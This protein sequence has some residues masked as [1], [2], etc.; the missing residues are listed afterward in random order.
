[1]ARSA[2]LTAL[3]LAALIAAPA[4]HAAGGGG[5]AGPSTV[6]ALNQYCENIPGPTGGHSPRPGAPALAGALPPSVLHRILK[7]PAAS[8]RRRLLTLPADDRT[9]TINGAGSAQADPLGLALPLML[10]ML[11]LGLVLTVR[12]M[13]TPRHAAARQ[14]PE[15]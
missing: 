14:F 7:A 5:C 1:M 4:A 11:A 3:L 12:A 8:T 13:V 2:R 6:S 9:L 10:A 15:K